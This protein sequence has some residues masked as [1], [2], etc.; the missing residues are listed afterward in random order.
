MNTPLA[1]KLEKALGL[2]EGYFVLLLRFYPHV[3]HQE[4]IPAYIGWRPAIKC[5]IF[6]R[7]IFFPRSC[8]NALTEF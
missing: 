6:R 8:T 7:I 2:E 1:L 5:N 3:G 4:T